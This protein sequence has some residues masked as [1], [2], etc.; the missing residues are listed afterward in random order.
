MVDAKQ[1]VDR[2]HRIGAEKHDKIT[3]ID[4]IT[5]GSIEEHQMN[6]LQEKE[7]RAEEIDRDKDKM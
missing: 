6:V 4:L 1:G 7:E 3:I 2:I 5:T